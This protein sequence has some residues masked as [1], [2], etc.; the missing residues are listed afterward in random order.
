MLAVVANVHY[1]DSNLHQVLQRV[2]VR[3][4][5]VSTLPSRERTRERSGSTWIYMYI[6]CM[7]VMADAVFL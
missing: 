2:C 7:G 5:V 3:K 6:Q 1:G 4:N